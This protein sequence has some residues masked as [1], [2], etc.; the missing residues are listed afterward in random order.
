MKPY[1]PKA[2]YEFARWVASTMEDDTRA[3]RLPAKGVLACPFCGHIQPVALSILRSGNG[4]RSKDPEARAY[5]LRCTGCACK[6]PWEK[7]LSSA[8]R[9]WNTRPV[10]S[11]GRDLLV[12]ARD[13]RNDEWLRREIAAFLEV[14]W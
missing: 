12:M 6:G 5:Y 4:P 2:H 7:S 9:R 11:K 13:G 10:A 14:P 1:A 3:E 8:L